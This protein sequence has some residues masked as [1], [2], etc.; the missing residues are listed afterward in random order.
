MPQKVL[1]SPKPGKSVRNFGCLSELLVVT[2]DITALFLTQLGIL[3]SMH[4]PL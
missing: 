3:A 1:L 4:S 2:A